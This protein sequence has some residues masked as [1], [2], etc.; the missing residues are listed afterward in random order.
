M[1]RKKHST[2]GS[3][4]DLNE[5][6]KA[7]L[8]A[9]SAAQ[10]AEWAAQAL[11]A[12]EQLR[13]K[14][15]PLEGFRLVQE[16]RDVL[17]L[18]PGLSRSVKNK[19]LKEQPSFT[20][21]EVASV[22]MALAEDVLEGEPTKQI[23]QLMIAKQLLERLQK[24]IEGAA[25]TDAKT[26]FQLKVTLSGSKPPIWRRIQVADCTL[27]E[28]HEVIQTAMGWTNSHL[29]Q[30]EI[31]GKRYGDPELLDDGFD[32]FECVDSTRT[33]LS[34]VLPKNRR[35]FQFAYEYDFG[36]GWEHE[37]VFE[38]CPKPEPGKTYPLCMEGERACPP[39]DIGGIWGYAEFLEALADPRHERH[40]EF[41]EWAGPFDPEDFDA[42]EATTAMRQEGDVI[43]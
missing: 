24:R 19:L 1:A 21:A 41:M 10:L 6:R 2:N 32:D 36:D 11:V 4:P 8:L 43:R 38:G 22:T 14:T 25:E 34:D 31:R 12:A 13:I 16:Q 23:A 35:R 3:S 26:L 30:F 18:L 5:A 27:D 40:E 20:V 17:L 9:D 39:E 28:L 7:S 29:H 37:V 15:K 33:N 42:A